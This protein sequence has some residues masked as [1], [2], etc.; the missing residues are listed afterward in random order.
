MVN[1]FDSFEVEK[2]ACDICCKEIPLSEAK[3]SEAVDYVA[4]FCGLECYVK[5]KQESEQTEQQ[6]GNAKE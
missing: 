5:W 2:V 1:E 3:T 4:Y 6:D